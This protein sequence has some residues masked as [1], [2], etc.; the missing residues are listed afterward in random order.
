MSSRNYQQR[1]EECEHKLQDTLQALAQ[2][3]K[4]L[5]EREREYALQLSQA[6]NE[7]ERESEERIV[8]KLQET[9]AL[10]SQRAQAHTD[11]L[12]RAAEQ[13]QGAL[14]KVSLFVLL[15]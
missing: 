8:T 9:E 14:R 7:K 10:L 11:A 1:I 5:V 6:L 12:L 2:K 4:A 13:H 3:D 15:Y